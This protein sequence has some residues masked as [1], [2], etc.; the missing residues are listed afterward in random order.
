MHQRQPFASFT[1]NFNNKD[2]FVIDPIGDQV[3]SSSLSVLPASIFEQLQSTNQQFKQRDS[4]LYVV[5]GYGY[6]ATQADHVT[7]KNLTAIDIEGVANAVINGTDITSFFR[8][9]TDS[10]MGVT[11]GQLGYLDSTFYLAGGQYFE[12]RYNPMG[13]NNGPGFIQAYTDEIRTF[14]IVDDGTNL[15]ITNYAAQNSTADLHRRDYNMAPQIFPNGEHGFTMFSGVFDVNDL[16]FLNSVDI[17]AS[18]YTVNNNF[19]QYLSQYQ[20]AKIPVYDSTDKAMHTLFFGGMSQY[21][22]DASG[23]LV[24]N[25]SVP[26]V[27]TISKVTRLQDSSMQ[28]IKLDIEMPTLLGAGS[29]F[30]PVSDTNIYIDGEILKINKL[31]VQKT[32]I[33]YIYGGIESTQ[34][35]IFFINDGTQSSASNQV[36]GV[37]INKS[38]ASVEDIVLNGDNIFNLALSPNPAK[39]QVLVDFY[40]PDH[41]ALS[42]EIYNL[43]GEL[44]QSKDVTSSVGAKQISLDITDLPKGEYIVRIKGVAA[45]AQQKLIKL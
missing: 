33:G 45:S 30:I 43:L 37:Y 26:F 15:S 3:W 21:T 13:P 20:S 10:T 18:G 44:V 29:D 25:D 9:V 4:T 19:T 40:V 27:K 42:L 34:P 1:E 39:E 2:I 32:L 22:L 8:Q 5:G 31:P 7:Y 24:Q 17:T 14:K 36:F 41:R 28:E 6:S 35:N 16:P 23:N 11:G 12:G 38:A